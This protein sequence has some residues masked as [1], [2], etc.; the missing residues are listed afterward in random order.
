[1][2]DKKQIGKLGFGFMRLPRVNGTDHYDEDEINQMVDCFMDAGFT[3][4]DTA[5]VYDNGHSEEELKKALV[6]RYPRD[7]YTI[8][9]KL[10]VG[11][12]ECTTAEF[13]RGELQTSLERLGCS[14]IDYYL[15]HAVQTEN[16]DKFDSFQLWDFIEEQK[17][18][19]VIREVGFSF[20]DTPEMLDELLTKHPDVDFVQLQLNYA[21]WENP[22]V[23][24]HG[25]YE[26]AR[27]H[28]KPIV[29]MEPVKGGL[30]ANP[31][32][33]IRELFQK[34]EPDASPASFAI[35]FVA[36][37]PGIRTVLSGMSTLEQVQDNVSYMKDFNPLSQ[38]ENELIEEARKILDAQESIP[39]TG[40]RYCVKG[41]P[42]FIPIPDIFSACN[43]LLV[44]ENKESARR[45]YKDALNQI[46]KPEVF[47]NMVF[48][49][50]TKNAIQ[51]VGNPSDCI[52][53]RQCEAACPQ[54][55]PITQLLQK[56]A[57]M[58][59]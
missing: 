6:D 58:L 50:E 4:F 30:L 44:F 41:C 17:A 57:A 48:I 20:H 39:C 59:E 49:P 46:V 19:G 16:I 29:V 55:L 12:K 33:A 25:I 22:H 24:S 27:K 45:E 11:I 1:M 42:E 14:F 21:D 34:E 35:R 38:K 36:S 31:P 18:K 43:R 52:H 53:C 10:N 2:A 23:Q 32:V 9:T 3:Y 28:G 56:A 8:A 37:L 40:C 15:L 51:H 5:Y 26:V 7:R 13:A 47:S 54:H